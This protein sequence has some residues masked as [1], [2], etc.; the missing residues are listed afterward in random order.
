MKRVFISYQ[1]NYA[2]WVA[3]AVRQALERRETDVFMDVEDIDSGRFEN[4]ILNQ[5]G[6][7]E[8]FIV[9]LTPDTARALGTEGDWVGRELQR[10]LELERNVIP[11][12]VDDASVND[13]AP[14]FARRKEVLELNFFRLPHDL[15]EQAITVLI[16]RFLTQPTLQELRIRTAK[17]HYETAKQAVAS[18]NWEVAEAE[19][20]KAIALQTRPEYFFGRALAKHW[21]GRDYEAL[22]DLDAAISLDPFAF[23]LMNNK[24]NLLQELDRLEDALSF[25]K[26][27]D[28]QA[29][30]Q[31]L[32]F[33]SRIIERLDRQEDIVTAVH[34]IPELVLLY[35]D[36]PRYGEINESLETLIEHAPAK[37][38]NRLY[39][40]LK[41]WRSASTSGI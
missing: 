30:M 5:I 32:N 20:E 13:I 18:D 33:G 6:L 1:R 40:E 38:A 23:E 37:M 15:F 24:F 29:E 11:V 22:N 41:T 35:G 17:E 21:L 14:G 10:A 27:W 9:L 26:S 28:R 19:Y 2:K 16:E 36:L 12:L 39:A 25:K 7:C 8:H 34:S 31:A 4:V 3:R